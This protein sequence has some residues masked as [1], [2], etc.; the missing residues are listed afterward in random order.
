MRKYLKNDAAVSAVIGVILMLAITVAIAGTVYVYLSTMTGGSE[1]NSTLLSMD[2]ELSEDPTNNALWMV[3]SVSGN[4][5]ED[6]KLDK[7]LMTEIGTG[8]DNASF[9]FNDVNGDGY[10]TPG[11]TYKVTASMDDHFTFLITDPSGTIIYK[12]TFV[13]Y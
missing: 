4:P 9:K 13:H 3:T 11:D 6:S 2:L 5:V 10:V 7:A 12:S 1:S 8:D